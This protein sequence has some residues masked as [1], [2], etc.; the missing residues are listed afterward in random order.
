MAGLSIGFCAG[1]RFHVPPNLLD[2]HVDGAL[3]D[4]SSWN[5]RRVPDS[6]FEGIRF[7]EARRLVEVSRTPPRVSFGEAVIEV[8]I[9]EGIHPLHAGAFT[10]RGDSDRATLVCGPSGTGKST[11]TWLA[12]SRG[13]RLISDDHVGFR[14]GRSNIAEILPLRRSIA[15]DRRRLSRIPKSSIEEVLPEGGVKVRFDPLALGIERLDV[16][17]P[18]CIVFLE[19]GPVRSI[20]TL[21]PAQAFGR[22][23]PLSSAVRP[24]AV[25]LIPALKDL[26]ETTRTIRASLTEDCLAD[27]SLL[28]ELG[29]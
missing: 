26:L 7:D 8:L 20:E 1:E 23:I 21:T 24:S 3:P 18:V 17:R 6:S 22:I 28:D 13:R 14:A 5:L 29:I 9:R 2:W 19:R 10:E 4:V 27:P 12:V 16:A 25:R 15:V 11:L